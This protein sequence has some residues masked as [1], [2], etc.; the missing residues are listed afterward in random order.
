[1]TSV[2]V[3]INDVQRENRLIRDQLASAIERAVASGRY[4][5]GPEVEAFER[6]FALY[7][8][9]KHCVALANGTD[10]LELAL[11]ALGIS[12]GAVATVANAGLYATTAIFQSGLEPLYID[13]DPASMTMDPESLGQSITSDTVAVIAT[14]LYGQMADLPAIL[15][16][17]E[18]AGIPLI[19]DC[20][21]AHGAML[22][23]RRAGSWGIAGCFSFYPTKNLGALGD[24]GAVIT[25]EPAMADRIRSLRQYGW[26]S[27]YHSTIP[28]GRNSRLDELQAAVLRTKLDHLDEWNDRRRAIARRYSAAFRDLPL[29]AP[30]VDNTNYV[31][32]LYVVRTSDRHSLQASLAAAGVATDIHYPIPD[33]RQESVLPRIASL[34]NLPVT[35]ACAR[36]VLTL[37]CFPGM[38]PD[39]V[40][41]VIGSVRSAVTEKAHA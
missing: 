1:M 19:E 17:T 4:I 6:E 26:T 23:G 3:P 12:R 41:L 2:A 7:S 38:T 18:R 5:L 15:E 24:G 20:A 34:P 8:G 28:G 25:S 14:H 37:P 16:I 32:H 10:A 40:E 27:K 9:T 36:E 35:E 11:K 33:Y 21:Q 30:A 31:A 22:C 39:E 13:V 29:T